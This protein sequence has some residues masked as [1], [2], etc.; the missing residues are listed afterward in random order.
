MFQFGF[1][2]QFL[3]THGRVALDGISHFGKSRRSSGKAINFHATRVK[4]HGGKLCDTQFLAKLQ[5]G[6]PFDLGNAN[7]IF[8]DNLPA[9]LDPI[10]VQCRQLLEMKIK[11]LARLAP[12]L[13]IMQNEI[14]TIMRREVARS[15]I[16]S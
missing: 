4:V 3:R 15:L 14:A 2:L 9:A 13:V 7:G 5:V 8:L 10:R 6:A 16:S 11:L 1:K 12:V